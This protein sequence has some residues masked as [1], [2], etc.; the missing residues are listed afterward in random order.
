[1]SEDNIIEFEAE[2]D[3]DAAVEA[4]FEALSFRAANNRY[5]RRG[6]SLT[7]IAGQD[8]QF[9]LINPAMPDLAFLLSE[10]RVEAPHLYH[11]KTEFP[12]GQPLGVLLGEESIYKID[13]APN[14]GARLRSHVRFR[15]IHMT[16]E[17]RE[18]ELPMLVISVNDDLARLK[19][20]IEEGAEAAEH[21]G[22][23]D[24]ILELFENK[25]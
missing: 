25:Q 6:M 23:M 21:A 17:Q 15:T 5:A 18:D 16:D 9:E 11:V 7:A 19:A 12:G 13:A 3:I 2:I 22:A 1:M 10:L 8:G 20:L 24:E 14:G 4:V